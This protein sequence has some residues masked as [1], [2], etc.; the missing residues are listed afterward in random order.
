VARGQY[1]NIFKSPD[2]HPQAPP[3]GL[4]SRAAAS[5]RNSF[6]KSTGRT[7]RHTTGPARHM[8]GLPTGRARVTRLRRVNI[9]CRR[10][11]NSRSTLDDFQGWERAGSTPPFRT[12]SYLPGGRDTRRGVARQ[13]KTRVT[14]LGWSLGLPGGGV[15]AMDLN[16]TRF[17]KRLCSEGRRKSVPRVG[18][19]RIAAP[20]DPK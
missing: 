10:Q 12:V 15:D 5:C 6:V 2:E 16:V 13:P 17:F 14:S 4:K 9:P 8:P 1:V 3:G 19:F 18:N 20:P 11:N 7:T